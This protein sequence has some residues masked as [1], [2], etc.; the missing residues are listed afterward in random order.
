MQGI[1]Q[2]LSNILSDINTAGWEGL[3]DVSLQDARLHILMHGHI[4][5]A[6]ESARDV[7]SLERLNVAITLAN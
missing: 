4:V 7:V 2:T 5:W 1:V 3:Q 6:Y